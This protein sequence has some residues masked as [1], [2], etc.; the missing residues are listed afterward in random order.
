MNEIE[1]K[2]SLKR[3]NEETIQEITIDFW[4]TVV[5]Q[6]SF[7]ILIIFFVDRLQVYQDIWVR[8]FLLSGMILCVVLNYIVARQHIKKTKNI[9]ESYKRFVEL[10]TNKIEIIAFTE[11]TEEHEGNHIPKVE[12]LL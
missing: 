6:S 7:V 5:L 8:L 12:D 1:I 10:A 2:E 9:L 4:A 3:K 11:A